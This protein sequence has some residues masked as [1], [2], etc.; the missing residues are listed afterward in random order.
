M[1]KEWQAKIAALF[2]IAYSVWWVL[3]QYSHLANNPAFDYFASTYCLMALWGAIWGIKIAQK[4]G[5][6]RSLMGKSI[7]FFSFGLFAQA[8]GQIGYS[9]YVMVLH[10]KVPY[11]SIGDLGYF[12]SIPLYIIGVS[13]LAHASGITVSVKTLL[14]KLQAII[15]PLLLLVVSYDIFL[16]NYAFDWTHPL[17][18]FLDFGYPLGQSIYIAIAV[19]TYLLSRK[20]LGGKMK[21]RVIFIMLALFIQYSADFIFLYQANT[22]EW[23]AAGIN[24][25][26][27]FVGYYIMTLGLLQLNTVFEELRSRV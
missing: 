25:F 18:V 17:T 15:I 3:L 16:K 7:L 20:M 21:K 4:W 2:F 13:L 1:L 19:L 22:G 14:N 26:I 24:D 6:W 10:I 27:Y 23:L 12:G 8:F 9:Y 5:G 11:P